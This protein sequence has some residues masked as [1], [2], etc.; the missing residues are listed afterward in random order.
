MFSS[1]SRVIEFLYV[2]YMKIQCRLQFLDSFASRCSQVS[3]FGSIKCESVMGQPPVPFC[4]RHC[5]CP[6][7]PLFGPLPLPSATWNMGVTIQAYGAVSW[8]NSV[9]LRTPWSRAAI[10]DLDCLLLDHL[11]E[12]KVTSFLI[13]TTVILSFLSLATKPNSNKCNET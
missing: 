9:A 5:L 1:F 7:F 6:V 13:Y 10:A 3:K 11:H 2:Q 4:K 12:R 8:M